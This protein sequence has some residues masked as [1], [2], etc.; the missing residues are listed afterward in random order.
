LTLSKAQS[1]FLTKVTTAVPDELMIG[2][3]RIPVKI[4]HLEHKKLQF[5]PENPRI[6]SIIGAG[7]KLPSQ[8]EIEARLLSMEH[9]KDLVQDIK[10]NGGLIDPIIVKDGS[11]EVLEGNSR[12][13]A[14]RALSNDD[15]IKWGYIKCV[16]LPPDMSED[17]IF[18]LLGQYHIKGKK[19][20]AP[21][22][23]AGFLYRRHKKQG[24]EISALAKEI[25]IGRGTVR[26]LVDTY[27]FMIDHDQTALSRWSY[28]FEYLKS[29]KIKKA[30]GA[31]EGFDKLIVDK[32]NSGE[33]TKATD[34][35]DKLPIITTASDNVLKKF[36]KKELDFEQ[37]YERAVEAGGDNASLRKLSAFRKWL[38]RKEVQ[39]EIM[40]LDGQAG[41][42][43][44]FELKRLAAL[45]R[46]ISGKLDP[47]S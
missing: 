21:F 14:Y 4:C 36:V 34:I 37:A 5:Y 38:G 22:E 45:T 1:P 41:K 9:V 2:G 17:A 18:A 24:V 27:Q 46:S 10:R 47:D 43:A 44:H 6:F 28:F 23:Q 16:L 3:K 8:E 32:V 33:I 12:L 20:W 40:E 13:A 7:E 29:N 25:G 35:R 42:R 31:S 26:Q 19:D 39:D 15:P 30:R 11:L